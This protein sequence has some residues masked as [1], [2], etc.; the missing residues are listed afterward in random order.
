MAAWKEALQEPN[1]VG[2]I[3]LI[4]LVIVIGAGALYFGGGHD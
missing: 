2:W 4:I 1:A 3:A